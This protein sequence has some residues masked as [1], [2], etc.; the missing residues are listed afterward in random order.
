M[1]L[2][3][4]LPF[5]PFY[6]RY[7]KVRN[8]NFASFGVKTLDA[9]V[10][11][12]RPK[13]EPENAPNE[14]VD[15]VE[16]CGYE[17]QGYQLAQSIRADLNKYLILPKGADIAITLWIMASFAIDSFR[18]FPKLCL[19][20][21]EKR[22]GKTTTL[23][24]IQ[25]F[26]KRGLPASNVSASVLFRA[27]SSWKPTLLIDEADTFISTNEELRGII[28]SGHTKSGAFVLRTEKVDDEWQPVKFSTWSP[29]VIAMIKK[30]PSTIIDRSI[31]I[32]LQ[33]K[34]PNEIT[35]KL[36]I[37]QEEK[38]KNIRSELMQWADDNFN[39]LKTSNPEIP[40]LSS[41]RAMDNWMPLLAVA[42]SIGW[43]DVARQSTLIL[44]DES[45]DEKSV[46]TKLLEDIREIFGNETRMFSKE[47]V[48]ALV[49]DMDN[50][51]CE[52]RHGNPMTANSLSRL[53]KPYKIHPKTMR[54]GTV[55]R[56][57]YEITQF[58][59]SFSRYLS[60]VSDPKRDTV[61]K[62]TDRALQAS[63]SV[64]QKNLVTD[65]NRLEPVVDKDC[66][67]VTGA[68][69]FVPL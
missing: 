20:S 17:V 3:L 21:P 43:G 40:K 48:F 58:E 10:E 59:D 61:T 57:G 22:C 15:G 54:I 8:F 34:K 5:Y 24:V 68:K 41:D 36:P 66:H 44:N 51:W 67:G 25:S 52:W 1:L 69:G 62:A 37:D 2:T 47:L 65:A 12:V 53:L 23:E 33:R 56:K 39:G 50:I 29:M 27:I 49:A 31:M 9:E 35:Q 30:P 26:S 7:S 18:I 55:R 32:E 4:F 46:E 14:L 19:S 38:N 6:L 11:S 64:T 16:P 60:D 28:N 42:D 63:Q 45:E 13:Q